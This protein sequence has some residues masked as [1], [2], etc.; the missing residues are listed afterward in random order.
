MELK[1]C[2]SCGNA[3]L[4]TAS[5]SEGASAGAG[6]CQSCRGQTE[7][8]MST[9]G[10]GARSVRTAVAAAA[11][12][13]A[14]PPR[15]SGSVRLAFD[16]TLAPQAE[17]P[18]KAPAAPAPAVKSPAF[19]TPVPN[20]LKLQNTPPPKA[21]Q[22]KPQPSPA[23]QQPSLD[24]VSM[25]LF[26]SKTILLKKQQHF[27]AAPAA[28]S[29]I[30]IAVDDSLEENQE[31][32]LDLVPNP[33][34][35]EQPANTATRILFHCLHCKSKLVVRPVSKTS[36]MV[37]PKCQ[38]SMFIDS[39][40]QLS[41]EHPDKNGSFR[42]RSDAPAPGPPGRDQ[43]SR[44]PQ[45]APA[46]EPAL[47]QKPPAPETPAEPRLRSDAAS[48]PER[49]AAQSGAAE[50]PPGAQGPSASISGGAP[51]AASS[52]SNIEGLDFC[53]HLSEPRRK[54]RPPKV[55][56]T[57]LEFPEFQQFRKSDNAVVALLQA[58]CFGVVLA[59]P[60]FLL[61]H[62]MSPERAKPGQEASAVDVVL[63]RT[64]ALVRQG[65]DILIDRV[66]RWVR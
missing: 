4:S 35:C 22:A 14:A 41:L 45:A 52:P 9:G 34:G 11:E 18:P 40:A 56:K 13:P 42:S 61:G 53:S 49:S 15:A 39:H 30:Q 63:D 8:A 26:S 60:L 46:K 50:P 16:E 7:S 21:P 17:T 37:C 24:N 27:G 19:P 6:L 62:W 65:L 47:E 38:Q 55:V 28:D 57:D 25:N 64:G 5:D 36:K 20:E 43:E 66:G 12:A 51:P 58:A 59:L 54:G 2:A 32:M 23:S 10:A 3:F 48:N 1:Y 29:E 31:A 44:E 33:W